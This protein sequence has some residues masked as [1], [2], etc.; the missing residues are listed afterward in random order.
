MFG[1]CRLSVLI[2]IRYPWAQGALSEGQWEELTRLSGKKKKVKKD[3]VQ[4][5]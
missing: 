3:F 5:A 1:F 2:M 4:L